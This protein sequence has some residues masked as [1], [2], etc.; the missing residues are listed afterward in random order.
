MS[1][2]VGLRNRLGSD[3]WISPQGALWERASLDLQ[4]DSQPTFFSRGAE[5]R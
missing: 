2:D 4:A 5:T 1:V 3:V